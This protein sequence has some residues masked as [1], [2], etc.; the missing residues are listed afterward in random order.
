V[1]T[2]AD[3]IIAQT[4]CPGFLRW[5][6]DGGPWQEAA[7][8]PVGGAM[9]AIERHQLR[10]GPFGPEVREVS[11]RFECT[12]AACDCKQPCCRSEAYRVRVE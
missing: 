8:K 11:I 7:L 6:I 5:S 9:T 12:H 3:A 10:L 1:A 2:R 4:N